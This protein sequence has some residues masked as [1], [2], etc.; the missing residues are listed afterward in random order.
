M[1]RKKIS[2]T[3][4]ADAFADLGE[5][6]P[7]GEKI[8]ITDQRTIEKKS[9]PATHD[10]PAPPKYVELEPDDNDDDDYDDDAPQLPANSVGA[11]LFGDGTIDFE[12]QSLTISIRREPDNFGDN[13]LNPC[14]SRLQFQPLRNV[15]L[16]A[17]RT[18]IEE[19]VREI[20]G[21]GHYFFQIYYNGEVTKTWR[22]SLADT[23]HAIQKAKADATAAAAANQPA[24]ASPPQPA[25]AAAAAPKS[26]SDQIKE[27]AELKE[28]LDKIFPAP[29]APPPPVPPPPTDL[30]LVMAHADSPNF[31]KLLDRVLPKEESSVVRD[32]VDGVKE[33]LPY[34]EQIGSFLRGLVGGWQGTTDAA[35]EPTEA[36]LLKVLQG[37]KAQS[38]APPK[39]N[40]KRR[41]K[42]KTETKENV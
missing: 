16:T 1:P 8:I 14:T 27:M 28:N 20:N 35:T 9:V 36:D 31:D 42:A 15:E 21:G 19:R 22:A 26:L 37:D 7:D 32:V 33:V 39:S 24:P 29:A 4:D 17:D 12:N 5:N 11:F 25:I 18:D 40:F 6:L 34:G 2:P 23:Q 13:F 3:P 30:G 41:A 38:E 10:Q